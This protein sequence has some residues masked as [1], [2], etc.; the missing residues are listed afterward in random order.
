MEDVGALWPAYDRWICSGSCQP[1]AMRRAEEE[2]DPR[3]GMPRYRLNPLRPAYARGS[4][5]S[6]N[7]FHALRVFDE[8]KKVMLDTTT[9]H[10]I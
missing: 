1:Y 5:P 7:R 10:H 2:V 9:L 6:Q 8:R 3:Q 4:R